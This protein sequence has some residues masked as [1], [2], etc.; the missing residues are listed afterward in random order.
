MFQKILIAN[1]GES[2]VRSIRACKELGIETVAIHS[3]LDVHSLHVQHADESICVGPPPSGQSYL[4]V[5]NIL[6]ACEITDVEAIHPGYGFLSEN[7]EFADICTSSG[8]KF[9]GPS[10]DNIRLMGNKAQARN[11]MKDAG[12]PVI[13]GSEG[14]VETEREAL[15]IARKIGL[16][17][18]IKASAGGGGKGMRVVHSEAS[19]PHLFAMARS[20]A[21]AAFN[22]A[23]VYIERY[24][25]KPRHIEIQILSDE[26][27][28][29]VQLGE[30]DCS[31]QRRHQKLIEES[32]SPA[33]GQDLRKRIGET[34]LRAAQAVG[35]TNAG[36]VEFILD[37]E[38][39]FYFMEMN[40]RIQVEHPVTEMVTGIDL[41]KE[42]IRIAAGERLSFTQDQVHIMGHSIE[43]RINAEDSETFTP[44][45]GLI[46]TFIPPGGPNVRVDTAVY[47]GYRVPPNYDSLLAKVIVKGRNRSEAIA[48]MKRALDEFVVQGIKTTIPFHKKVMRTPEFLAGDVYTT[49][50]E[51]VKI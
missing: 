38:G 34:A 36:T 33:L 48:I 14:V 22:D 41:I 4:N 19:L 47:S 31:I 11:T 6:S 32:P 17:V 20:E 18:I 29:M 44:C 49:F 23:S 1:R 40:T 26:M 16:P 35:Y 42:Q 25:E 43:C 10:A 46:E 15:E 39:D 9:I 2:A 7:A 24:I 12:V 21:A 30:R 37:D 13:P 8:I 45:P 51:K 5:P 27:G 3:D 28:N 50:L